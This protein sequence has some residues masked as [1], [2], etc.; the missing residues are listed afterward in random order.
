[1]W[2]WDWQGAP[3]ELQRPILGRWAALAVRI[4]HDVPVPPPV[5]TRVL[6]GDGA[7]LAE[8]LDQAA[9]PT[10]V[11]TDSGVWRTEYVFELP[12]SLYQAGHQLVHVID[13]D[14][15]LAETNEDDNVG[16]PI[17]LY[18]DRLEPFRVTFF[19]LHFTGDPPPQADAESLMFATRAF[20][21]I[22]ED[23][24]VEIA[25]PVESGATSLSLLLDEIRARWNAEGGRNDYYHGV[26][27]FPWP[28]SS[29]STRLRTAGIAEVPGNVAVS[30]L[31]SSGVVAHEFGHNL[32]LRHPPGCGATNSDPNYPYVN[33]A[34][35][36]V[37]G[38]DVN[39][40]RFVSGDDEGYT[41][42]MSYCGRYEF[43]S[44]Y[45]YRIASGWRPRVFPVSGAPGVPGVQQA[46]Q[47]GGLG[48]LPGEMQLLTAESDDGSGLALSGRIDAS[49]RWSLT[50]AR[51]ADRG[52]RAPA[53]D[54][55]FTLI[56]LDGAG[57]ELYRE[58]L[59]L[60]LL[61]HS[62]EAGWAARTPV[63]ESPVREVVILD[64]QGVEVLREALPVLE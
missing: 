48:P 19:P 57:V 12:G 62:D 37:A 36:P 31:S 44:G 32:S 16:E 39:W 15:V 35:G 61:S 24:E 14:D 6:D 49:G 23:Y 25:A 20:L 18:G 5:V 13:P 50:H 53:P 54:G 10:T 46:A 64:A 30:T 60:S 58:P 51:G 38:W 8:G 45:Q 28:G 26:F 59:S 43:I 29:E 27:L 47:E 3:R 22:A 21:P 11:S 17:V 40:R 34:L 1:M 7:V 55:Q 42:V 41:D 63:P 56:L 2:E 9:P 52:P 4:D 33:G